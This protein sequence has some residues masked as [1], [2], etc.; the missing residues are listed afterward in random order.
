MGELVYSR[1]TLQMFNLTSCKHDHLS[2]TSSAVQEVTG[3]LNI[4]DPISVMCQDVSAPLAL[5]TVA[6]MRPQSMNALMSPSPAPAWAEAAYTGRCAYVRCT[7]D[8]AIFVSAQ[9]LM[10][11]MS[12]VDWIIHTMDTGHSPFLSCPAELANF[13]IN[14]ASDLTL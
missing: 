6:A 8:A 14:L 11:K 1:R 13:L 7:Q 4:K 10:L 3:Q 2:A 5:Q 9:D 12:G